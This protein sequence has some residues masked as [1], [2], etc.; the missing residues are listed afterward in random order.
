MRIQ[1]FFLLTLLVFQSCQ[2]DHQSSVVNEAK[3]IDDLGIEF[4]VETIPK[5]VITLAPNLTELVFEL[6]EGRSII[7]NTLYCNYPDSAHNVEKVGDLLT[8]NLEKI[9]ELKPDIIFLT[10]EGNTKE[11]YDKLIELGQKVF[12]SN[13]KNFEG[14]KKSLK[15]IAR[16]FKKEKYAEKILRYW[17]N[18]FN[19]VKT[20]VKGEKPKTA[21]FLIAL[22]PI[23][24]AGKDTYINEYLAVCNLK[25]IADD[26]D[27]SYPVF[28]RE[29]VL[30]R[31][32]D[33]IIYSDGMNED[34]ESMKNAYPE[35]KDLNAIKN[36]NIIF[37]DADLYFRPGPRFIVALEDLASRIY[38][39]N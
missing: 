27:V 32:P 7:G 13:P 6:G 30:N 1:L 12:V 24:L 22:Q 38:G 3:L 5:R 14:I 20:I 37:I 15:D 25:N 4:A 10:V 9:L 26:T 35:W 28:S 19:I 2:K 29:Q 18:R 23:M 33:Y 17:S 34:E 11:S 31:D 8:I 21:M 39:L 36:G 16:I